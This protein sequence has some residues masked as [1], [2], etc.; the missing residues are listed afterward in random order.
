MSRVAGGVALSPPPA[1]GYQKNCGGRL[2]RIRSA[3]SIPRWCSSRVAARSMQ[4]E[5]W[6]WQ[7][8]RRVT[9]LALRV[10]K[11]YDPA[12]GMALMMRPESGRKRSGVKLYLPPVASQ[13]SFG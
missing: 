5:T 8:T 10:Q 2:S 4:S 7:R 1:M 3:M 6:S 11:R 12:S 9:A 13:R